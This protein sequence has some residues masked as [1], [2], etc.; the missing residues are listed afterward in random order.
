MAA[1]AHDASL[2]QERYS[3]DSLR[4][5]MLE[6]RQ[7]LQVKCAE[8]GDLNLNLREA[9]IARRGV[10]MDSGPLVQANNQTVREVQTA[11]VDF[12]LPTAPHLS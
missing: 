5:A 2:H 10:R 4:K 12:A 6:N 8:I 11:G 7:V 9:L 1:R 3:S